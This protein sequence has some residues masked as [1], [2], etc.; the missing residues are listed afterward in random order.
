MEA[1]RVPAQLIVLAAASALAGC[2]QREVPRVPASVDA[3][4]RTLLARPAAEVCDRVHAGYFCRVRDELVPADVRALGARAITLQ[5][6]NGD[7]RFVD[8]DWGGGHID[9]HG[10]LIGPAGWQHEVN[11]ERGE[12]RLRDGVYGYDLR[13]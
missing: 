11:G 9:A 3:W 8:L 12:R 10:V 6:V 13:Q 4:A 1:G 5:N 7:V 2:S